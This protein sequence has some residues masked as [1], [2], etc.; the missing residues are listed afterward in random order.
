MSL[1]YSEVI[2]RKLDNLLTPQQYCQDIC[3]LASIKSGKKGLCLHPTAVAEGYG[4]KCR[5]LVL[6]VLTELRQRTKRRE[7]GHPQ[8][9]LGVLEFWYFFEDQCAKCS[10]HLFFVFFN[11]ADDVVRKLTFTNCSAESQRDEEILNFWHFRDQCT[12][13]YPSNID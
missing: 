7:R 12:P 5:L 8:K 11:Q 2:T 9:L 10:Y 1:L 13:L 6:G 3:C 4:Q